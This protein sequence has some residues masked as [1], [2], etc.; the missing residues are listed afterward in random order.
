MGVG[1]FPHS[2][3]VSNESCQGLQLSIAMFASCAFVL[4]GK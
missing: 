3:Q 2:D 1:L 4:V